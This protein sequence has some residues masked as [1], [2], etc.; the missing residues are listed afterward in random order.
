M[1]FSADIDHMEFIRVFSTRPIGAYFLI[2][3]LFCSLKILIRFYWLR[4]CIKCLSDLQVKNDLRL[5][6]DNRFLALSSKSM[7]IIA[8]LDNCKLSEICPGLISPSLKPLV[9]DYS[10]AC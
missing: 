7:Q 9:E 8:I 6:Q 3:E 4:C 2:D 5:C 10:L 1:S